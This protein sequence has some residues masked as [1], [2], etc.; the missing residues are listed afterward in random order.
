MNYHYPHPKYPF[1]KKHPKLC[2]KYLLRGLPNWW[3]EGLKDFMKLVRKECG[4]SQK[5]FWQDI[6]RPLKF[7]YEHYKQLK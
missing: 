4:Y 3:D 2:D 6:W 7:S 1:F 5:T